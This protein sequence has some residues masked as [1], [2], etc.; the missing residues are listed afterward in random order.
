MIHSVSLQLATRARI[1]VAVRERVTTV[2][3]RGTGAG[4]DEVAQVSPPTPSIIK[5]EMPPGVFTAW[6]RR[7]QRRNFQY[8]PQ[9]GDKIVHFERGHFEAVQRKPVA[10]PPP[11]ILILRMPEL[12]ITVVVGV[13]FMSSYLI[14]ILQFEGDWITRVECQL[15]ATSR[16][17]VDERAFELLMSYASDMQ[18]GADVVVVFIDGDRFVGTSGVVEWI[19]HDWHDG[20]YHALGVERQRDMEASRTCPEELVIPPQPKLASRFAEFCKLFVEEIQMFL[21]MPELRRFAC[22]RENL[23]VSTRTS[24][25]PI[26]LTLFITR[27]ANGRQQSLKE[28]MAEIDC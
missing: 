2:T 17:P 14:L 10:F 15:L 3:V 23:E 19:R 5:E 21:G 9:F 8:I 16:W 13:Q 11:F 28:L 4:E 22:L 1:G 27:L 26:D 20:P 18:P 25:K 12:V 24:P 7:C 6:R